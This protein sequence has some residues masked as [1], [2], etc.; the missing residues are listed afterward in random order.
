MYKLNKI[1]RK[2]KKNIKNYYQKL[3][4]VKIRNLKF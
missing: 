1:N 4:E 2:K 3:K